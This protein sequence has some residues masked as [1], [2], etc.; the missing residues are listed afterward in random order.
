MGSGEMAVRRRMLGEVVPADRMARAVAFR[1]A[2][3]Q[4]S[5]AMIGPLLGGNPVRRRRPRGAAS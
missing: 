2:D 4:L 1:L 3:R 5:R